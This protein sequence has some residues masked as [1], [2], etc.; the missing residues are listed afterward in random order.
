MT[1]ANQSGD[2]PRAFVDSGPILCCS[3]L[4]TPAFL[5]LEDGRISGPIEDR[6]ASEIIIKG[7]K[8]RPGERMTGGAGWRLATT[9]GKKRVFAATLLKHSTLGKSDS[10]FSASLNNRRFSSNFEL[11]HYPFSL[12]SADRYSEGMMKSSR[13]L[14][15][16]PSRPRATIPILISQPPAS[17]PPT[18][19]S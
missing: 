6:M 10:Q 5:F 4:G 2:T 11:A 19:P 14:K 13:G 18:L 17:P 7:Q 8:A 16:I 3:F 15:R 9:K 1:F 12:R